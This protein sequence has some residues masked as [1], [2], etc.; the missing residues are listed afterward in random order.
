MMVPNVNKNERS[1]SPM[2]NISR[3]S[4]IPAL[5]KYLPKGN[6]RS[7]TPLQI[8]SQ[9]TSYTNI[10]KL[11]LD[12]LAN[13]PNCSIFKKRRST[14]AANLPLLNYKPKINEQSSIK[15]EFF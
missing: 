3:D 2:K 13:T 5:L 11:N 7:R 15:K 9:N 4:G 12:T 10:P 6:S 8:T 1:S 14:S